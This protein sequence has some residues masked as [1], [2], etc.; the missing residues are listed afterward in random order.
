[1]TSALEVPPLADLR[2][3]TSRETLRGTGIA[4]NAVADSENDGIKAKVAKAQLGNTNRDNYLANLMY[5]LPISESLSLPETATKEKTRTTSSVTISATTNAAQNFVNTSSALG[6]RDHTTSKLLTLDAA[7]SKEMKPVSLPHPDSPSSLD[8]SAVGDREKTTPNLPT[9]D[10]VQS[11]ET[12]SASLPHPGKC[13]CGCVPNTPSLFEMAELR[14]QHRL[15]LKNAG[16][17]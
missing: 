15:R 2:A 4:N 1:M 3:S 6:N 13:A 11:E 9:Q 14:R 17:S 5:C 16:N 8:S 10:A 7:E 12:K